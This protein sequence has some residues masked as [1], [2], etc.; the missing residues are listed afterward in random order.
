MPGYRS[1]LLLFFFLTN[2]ALVAQESERFVD[3][4]VVSFG[5]SGTVEDSRSQS[6]LT[7]FRDA[8]TAPKPLVSRQEARALPL[9]APQ[10]PAVRQV[11]MSEPLD[12][13][14]ESAGNVVSRPQSIEEESDKNA[15][16]ELQS[17]SDNRTASPP[18]GAFSLDQPI[19]LRMKEKGKDGKM[20]KPELG[21]ALAPVVSVIGSLLIVLS[22]FFIL[23]M[24]F[25]KMSPK[26]NRLLPK[27]AFENLGRS[28]LTPKLQLHLLRLGNRLILVSVTADGVTPVTEV[29]DPDEVVPLLGMCRQLDVNSSTALF[30]KMYSSMTDDDGP[31]VRNAPKKVA[32]KSK[33]NTSSLVDLYS[34]PEESLVD[35]LKGGAGAR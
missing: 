12:T 34:E 27:E 28:F 32:A 22:A 18:D 16:G 4:P 10:Q 19:G 21:K 14:V 3:R 9:P 26:G 33:S 6:Q 20:E 24:M 35:L 30:Q 8:L 15:S 2:A 7:G 5:P 1:V 23:M 25:R 11:A 17:A 13:A 29:T 31:T